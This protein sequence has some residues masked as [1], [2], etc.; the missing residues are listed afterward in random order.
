MENKC[1]KHEK[2]IL[3][4]GCPAKTSQEVDVTLPIDIRAFAD[5]GHVRIQC[6]GRPVIIKDEIEQLSGGRCQVSRFKIRQ[7]MRIEIPVVFKAET[8][9]GPEH[10]E[11]C[12]PKVE[13][14]NECQCEL[15]L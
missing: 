8:D 5:V 9:I 13:E 14:H 10:V 15:P 4:G 2:F 11:F 12:P 1:E 7:R 6:Q 3:N